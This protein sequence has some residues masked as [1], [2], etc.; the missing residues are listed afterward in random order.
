M[1]DAVEEQEEHVGAQE[2]R[3]I[4]DDFPAR[5]KESRGLLRKEEDQGGDACRQ[6]YRDS[7]CLEGPLFYPVRLSG[8]DILT[9]KG[10]GGGGHAGHR[11]VNEGI[12]LVVA[13]PAGHAVGAEE[14]DVGLHKYVGDR[15]DDGGDRGRKSDPED[16]AD[17]VP[18]QA[19]ISPAEAVDVLR[20]AEQKQDERRRE[21]LGED[22]GDRDALNAHAE[23]QNEEEIEHDIEK[24]GED[25]E[26]KRP[27]G[28]SDRPQDPAAH[29]VDEEPGDPGKID[30]K[31]DRRIP[32]DVLRGRHQEQ[33][34]PDRQHSR[35]RKED[36]G[37]QGHGD[38]RLHGFVQDLQVLRPVLLADHDAGAHQK[39]CEKSHRAGRRDR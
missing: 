16:P 38:R 10:G 34:G 9:D 30:L 1:A 19:Q 17:D 5:R 8:A 15:G 29:V 6:S 26:I 13:A 27:S 11:E 28:I 12:N 25:Q 22:R 20:A 39:R 2:E 32:H 33:H 31:I 35:G 36:P 3:G 14:I 24:A 37:D 4:G 18:V 23:L 21:E 7:H